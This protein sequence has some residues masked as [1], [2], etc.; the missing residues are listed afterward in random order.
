MNEP[1]NCDELFTQAVLDAV[2]PSA[3]KWAKRTYGALTADDLMQSAVL[4]LWKYRFSTP[5]IDPVR[6]LI[7]R[8]RREYS[9]WVNG[10]NGRFGERSHA[11]EVSPRQRYLSAVEYPKDDGSFALT[12]GNPVARWD[13]FLDIERAL[14]TLN[15]EEQQLIRWR[16]QDELNNREIGGKLGMNTQSKE[17]IS[18]LVSNMFSP[19]MKKLREVLA[20]YKSD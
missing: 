7:A 11:H 6:S 4:S 12:Q 14:H 5:V 8:V 16:Y 18:V 2:R 9:A 19:I 10:T 17:S 15:A 13:M 3:E 1:T 20:D